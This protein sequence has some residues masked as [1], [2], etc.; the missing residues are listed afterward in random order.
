MHS[1]DLPNFLMRLGAALAL[2]ATMGLERQWR[3]RMAG[4]R[5]NALVSAAA[6]AF[7]MIGLIDDT[8][9][10]NAS[11]IVGQIVSGI[12][13]LG[14][15]VIFKEGA[16]V[17]GLNTAATVWCAA[18]V[19]A[20][21]GMGYPQYSLAVA[22][23]AILTNIALRPLTYKWHGVDMIKVAEANYHFELICAAKDETQVRAILLNAVD[24]N[25]IGLTALH[26]EDMETAE[27]V[28]VSASLKT[29]ARNDAAME[30]LVARF[31]LEPGVNSIKWLV[32]TPVLE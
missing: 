23:G 9:Q 13:F 27:R 1:V 11:R 12:G 26:S 31:S 24:H 29:P 21:C 30:Q 10:G 22:A 17:H 2:G 7:T 19:G 15:G 3:N 16:N 4:T 6:A 25:N 14:A 18:A 8:G 5:T 32:E 20:L 28:R